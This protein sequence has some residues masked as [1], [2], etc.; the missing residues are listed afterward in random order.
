MF[1]IRQT[2]ESA[3]HKLNMNSPPTQREASLKVS[4]KIFIPLIAV[5]LMLTIGGAISLWA[6]EQTETSSEELRKSEFRIR[7]AND[8]LSEIKDAETGQRGYVIT[9][10]TRFLEPFLAADSKINSSLT[11]L[12]KVT[13]NSDSIDRLNKIEPLVA[14]KLSDLKMVIELRQSGNTNAAIDQISSAHGKK[15]MDSLRKEVNDYDQI[16][17]ASL[18]K[19]RSSFQSQMN[20]LFGIIIAFCCLAALF[21]FLFA[22]LTYAK[23]QE[24]I[25]AALLDETKN[26][27]DMQESLNNQLQESSE[28]LR[29]SEEKLLVTLA[30]IGDGVIAT[31]SNACV[32][33]LNPVAQKL[34]GW[35]QEDAKGRLID[36]VFK[37]INEETGRPAPIPIRDAL[38]DRLVEGLE[39]HTAL[40]ARNGNLS[41]I[42]DSC[43][44]IR[45]QNQQIIGAVLVFR[46]VTKEYA[47]Q[48]NL[49]DSATQMQAILSAVGDGLIAY[50]ANNGI[51]I[52]TNLAAENMFGYSEHEMIGQ[53]FTQLVSAVSQEHYDY[54]IK[55]PSFINTSATIA[56]K[57]ESQGRKKNGEL[58]PLEI[59]ISEMFLNGERFF[60]SIIRDITAR[61]LAEEKSVK[62]SALQTAIFNSANFSSIATDANGVI[63]IFNV[64][65]ERMLGYAASD[66]INKITPADISDPIELVARAKALSTELGTPIKP[67]F[68]ALVF[69][70][71]RGIEDI[72]ELTYIRQDGSRFPALVSVTAL[73]DEQDQVIG[74]LLIGTDN[75][76][77]KEDELEQIK[78]DQRLRDHQFYTRS[79]IESNIDAM[80]TTDPSGIITD[81]NRQMGV[82]TDCTRDELIGSPFKN[83]FDDPAKAEAGIRLALSE[84][85]V[86]DYEL[87]ANA[88]NGI[89]TVVSFNAST[90][91]DRDRKLQGVFGAARDITERKLLDQELKNTN[92]ALQSARVSADK[93]NQAK[94]EFLSSMS[95]EIRTPMNAILGMSYLALKTDLTTRQRDYVKKIKGSGQHLLAIINDILDFSKIEAG[96]LTVE[97]TEFELR[98]VL[99]NVSNL[100]SEKTSAKGLELI[101]D[102]DKTVPLNLIGDP[103]RLAQ[104][105]INYSNNAVKFT[106][107]G[108]VDI[109]VRIEEESD[110][111]IVLHFSV[112]DTGIGISPEQVGRL[113]QSFSQADASTTRKF[114][115]TGL[116][117]AISKNLAELMGGKVGVESEPGK[118]S[119]FWFTARFGRG[120]ERKAPSILFKDLQGKRVL[121]VD[122]NTYARQLLSTMLSN[123]GFTADQAESGEEAILLF[124]Q[125]EERD[126][127]YEIVFIDCQMTNMNGFETVRKL[128]KVP[129]KRMPHLMMVA[130]SGNEEVI[131][132]AEELGMV[133]LLIKPIG[134]SVL[135]DSVVRTLGGVVDVTHSED[136]N[137]ADVLDMLSTIKGAHILLVEDNDI[138][139]EMAAELLR[140]VGFN[141]DLADN[142]LI[143]L[144]KVKE[145][146]YDAVLMDVQMPVMDGL[147]STREMRK[148]PQLVDLPII[149]MT[150]NAMKIDREN[151]L[152]AGMNDH[153]SKPV[154]PEVLWKALLRWIKPRFSATAIKKQAA[155]DTEFLSL[156]IQG[157]DT[158]SGMHRVRDKKLL[159]FSL[160]QKFIDGQKTFVS[161]IQKLILENDLGTAERL[162]HSLRG[163][164]A[165]IGAIELVPLAEKLE[166]ALREHQSSELISQYITSLEKPLADLLIALAL[167]LPQDKVNKVIAVDQVQLKKICSQLISTLEAGD[168]EA[169][170]IINAN[171]DILSSAFPLDFKRLNRDIQ[172]FDFPKA[173][174]ALNLIVKTIK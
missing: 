158:K 153:V 144:N 51:L 163:V 98:K 115:G 77:R 161:E 160:L 122:D 146:K 97:Y 38:A 62:A 151:C 87:T 34:T 121:V 152:A 113:F 72:Y 35:S 149:A 155:T 40:I 12:K 57:K 21:M 164:A 63:Q 101:I 42:A 15:L 106:E 126:T 56:V 137:D 71:S 107:A 159:Y 82:L 52:T 139:Q 24:K 80:M 53:N 73:R 133:D 128:K 14:A 130:S 74:Y 54:F 112:K 147:T 168:S 99:E 174:F 86:T 32:T 89:K 170:E 8:L 145:T 100:I 9:G 88:R 37:I 43:A 47:I 127:P 31:D 108:E 45:D 84:K 169:V 59:T 5:I 125:S 140:D 95:H 94:S 114:G 70:A 67:G 157:L 1:L 55:N 18:L 90:F 118:G 25:K 92:V 20:L 49:Q 29:I 123:M 105:L 156:E 104:I 7:L 17:S 23:V 120:V 36:D 91:Y 65:A 60:T 10:N 85:K 50:H 6:F 48:Q 13:K 150:A 61:K 136:I 110:K 172:S 33:L 39:K 58:F 41:S 75:T 68:E 66:V 173:L 96:K 131:K 143:A 4:Y 142:G 132:G 129:L 138:N 28:T 165:N 124:T 162:A 141:V 167:K 69:K 64:G 26:S 11:E 78:L 103:L 27:L 81:V 166:S 102:I 119:T 111:N 116:G 135:F 44:P 134:A 46:D 30:S 79:L 148:D 83:Y 19:I 3:A 171:S 117:L 16:E 154:E 2:N 76:A 22:Y 109:V 93:A